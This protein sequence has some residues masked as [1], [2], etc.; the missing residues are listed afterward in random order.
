MRR[1]AIVLVVISVVLVLTSYVV[2]TQRVAAVLR[3]DA[4]LAGRMYAQVYRALADTG[5]ESPTATLFDLAQHIRESGVPMILT[6]REGRPQYAANLPFDFGTDARTD[7][8]VQAW[9]ARLDAE[10][11]PVVEPNVGTVIHFG[12]TPL[13]QRL[14]IIPVLQAGTLAILLLVGVYL[15]RTRA[16]AERERVWAGMARESAHQLGTPLSSLG[17]WIELLRDRGGAPETERALGH[18]VSD[19][20]RLE[21]VAH[22]FERIGRPPQ[23][24]KF[25][26][27]AT[28]E[29]VVQYFAARL[30][31]LANTVTIARRYDDGPIELQGDAVLV[32]W[33]VEAL[34]KNAVD[35]LAG[36]GGA[37][38]VA[39]TRLPEGAARVRVSDDGPGIPRELRRRIFEA[40]FSTKQRGW[41][42]GLALTRRIVE[43]AHGGT[44]ALVPSERGATFEIIFPA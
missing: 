16:H 18:M 5:N 10:N 3:F 44:L 8:R 7:P 17:G 14:R 36:R 41:G 43:E 4:E 26:L 37:I 13:V 9:V 6:D 25:D 35:A 23:R 22:R 34:V 1:G 33:A 32:E 11:R 21:R 31:T 20:E 2:Y 24:E 38:E 19:V 27:T 12:H 40:G 42:I 30:P 15:L 28:V 39:C 29:H